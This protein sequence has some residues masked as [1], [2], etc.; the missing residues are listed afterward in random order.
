M[1]VRSSGSVR[2]AEEQFPAP[3]RRSSLPTS[4]GRSGLPDDDEH[5]PS[6]SNCTY[7]DAPRPTPRLLSGLPQDSSIGIEAAR[8]GDRRP[9]Q[10]LCP[11][12]SFAGAM[13]AGFQ[14][15]DWAT[16]PSRTVVVGIWIHDG[17]DQNTTGTTIANRASLGKLP[18]SASVI[19]NRC[20]GRHLKRVETAAKKTVPRGGP[21]P[22]RNGNEGAIGLVS[23]GATMQWSSACLW[24]GGCAVHNSQLCKPNLA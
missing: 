2:G 10:G 6:S 21:A 19:G 20:S 5:D 16:T 24:S 12:A 14:D 13:Q 18:S 8:D 9:Y 4:L 15:V 17:K 23:C 1:R 3:T 22:D 7:K 11:M